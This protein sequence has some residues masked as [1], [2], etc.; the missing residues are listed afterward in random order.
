MVKSVQG[1]GKELN[2]PIPA[3][4]GKSSNEITMDASQYASALASSSVSGSDIEFG[5]EDGD[6]DDDEEE[7]EDTE[8][9]EEEKSGIDEQFLNQL[10]AMDPLFASETSK[11]GTEPISFP[12]QTGQNHQSPLSSLKDNGDIGNPVTSQSSNNLLTPS[13]QT[14][15]NEFYDGAINL[16]TEVLGSSDASMWMNGGATPTTSGA[17]NG[18]SNK[19]DS[20]PGAL[21]TPPTAKQ[22]RNIQVCAPLHV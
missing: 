2:M 7:G 12:W 18:L 10:L 9:V 19:F 6:E 15:S 21:E 8:M 5:D 14:P 16:L 4:G 17:W 3:S 20:A 13:A 11:I 1:K 22:Y